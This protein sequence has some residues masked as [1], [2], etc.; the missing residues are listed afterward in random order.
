MVK[1]FIKNQ[2]TYLEESKETHSRKQAK[3]KTKK[4]KN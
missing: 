1:K 2:V 4:N 3:K